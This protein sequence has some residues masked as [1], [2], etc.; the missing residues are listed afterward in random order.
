MSLS[1]WLISSLQPK[2]TRQEKVFYNPPTEALL[3]LETD[4]NA[5][6]FRKVRDPLRNY[7]SEI[8]LELVGVGHPSPDIAL[9]IWDLIEAGKALGLGVSTHARSTLYDAGLLIWLAGDKRRI[10]RHSGFFQI[11][12]L[13]RLEKERWSSSESDTPHMVFSEPGWVAHYRE[14]FRLM[15]QFIP[16]RELADKRHKLEVLGEYGLLEGQEI[17]FEE[18][19]SS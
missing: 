3:D 1:A 18:R 8:H 5:E 10:R 11:S 9:A 16:A 2:R 19:S 15:N 13:D 14:V 12:C 6:L 4:T 17:V 7:P